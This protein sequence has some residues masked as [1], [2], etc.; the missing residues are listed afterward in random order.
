MAPKNSTAKVAKLQLQDLLPEE[1]MRARGRAGAAGARGGS[2]QY[3]KLYQN[4]LQCTTSRCIG[5]APGGRERL[6]RCR[7]PAPERLARLRSATGGDARER[8]K[9]HKRLAHRDRLK[10]RTR[11]KHPIRVMHH[12]HLKHRGRLKHRESCAAGIQ[13]AAAGQDF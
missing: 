13:H 7:R 1:C 9:H 11:L 12:K 4:T 2:A 8:W 5:V 3:T 10:H 6:P